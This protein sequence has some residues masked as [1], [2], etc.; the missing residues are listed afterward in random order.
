MFDELIGAEPRD[1]ESWI[2]CSELD[3]PISD[4]LRSALRALSVARRELV[5]TERMSQS[6][7]ETN[8]RDDIR[9]AAENEVETNVNE[10]V[11]KNNNLL[12]K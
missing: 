12:R 1:G 11:G 7:D 4:L 3:M 8:M 6:A 2:S 10:G 9:T 5:Y